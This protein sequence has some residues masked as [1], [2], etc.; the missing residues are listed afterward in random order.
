MILHILDR[1]LCV[2]EEVLVDDF[3]VVCS[4]PVKNL[5]PLAKSIPFHWVT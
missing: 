1:I 2:W 5:C 4:F 3:T